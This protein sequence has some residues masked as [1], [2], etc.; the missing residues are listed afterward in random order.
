MSSRSAA[1]AGVSAGV[2]AGSSPRC[3]VPYSSAT[4]RS[5]YARRAAV[6]GRVLARL[7]VPRERDRLN[8]DQV[9]GGGPG[10]AA[11]ED[12]VGGRW[13]RLAV[14]AV[15]GDRDRGDAA[16]AAQLDAASHV[17]VCRLRVRLC[18]RA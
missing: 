7:K 5:S 8:L 10:L 17:A 15:A 4:S 3:L 13:L 12:Q 2:A 18:V 9:L 1:T 16:G 11:P 14:A 6:A